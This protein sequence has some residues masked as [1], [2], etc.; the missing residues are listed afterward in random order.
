[1]SMTILISDKVDI[2]TK[3]IT[4]VCVDSHSY[5]TFHNDKSHVYQE[6]NY[7]KHLHTQ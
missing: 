2:K 1:M 7:P 6:D 5:W 3:F 4:V